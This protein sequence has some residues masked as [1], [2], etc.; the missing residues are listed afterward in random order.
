MRDRGLIAA[1][2]STIAGSAVPRAAFG[3]SSNPPGPRLGFNDLGGGSNA[4]EVSGSLFR[5]FPTCRK[6]PTDPRAPPTPEP[7]GLGFFARWILGVFRSPRCLSAS[8]TLSQPTR[9]TFSTIQNPQRHH[10]DA[11]DPGETIRRGAPTPTPKA[12]SDYRRQSSRRSRR[13]RVALARTRRGPKRN[14]FAVNI[15]T[16][17]MATT[18]KT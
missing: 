15:R 16:P 17:E 4:A 6:V 10:L 18:S 11:G 8:D 2:L 3:C 14:P 9:P 1:F 7:H 12:R 5:R 13:N